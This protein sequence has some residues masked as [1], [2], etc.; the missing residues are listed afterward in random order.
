M[1]LLIRVSNPSQ[2][3]LPFGLRGV[4]AASIAA[5]FLGACAQLPVTTSE[6]SAQPKEAAADSPPAAQAEAPVRVEPLPSQPLTAQILYQLLM[7][8]IAAQRGN[9]VFASSGYLDLARKTRDPRIARRAAEIAHFSRN[10]EAALEAIRLWLEFDPGSPQ[11]R[12]MFVGLLAQANRFDEMQPHVVAILEQEPAESRGEALMRLG[13]V[14][15]RNPDRQ[16]V[17]RGIDRMTEP[18]LNLPEARLLRAQAAN[19]AGVPDRAMAEIEAAIALRP[20][21]DQAVLF[22]AQLQQKDSPAAAIETI[23]QYLARY[24]KARDVR[25][26]Y[27]RALVGE[28]RY[29]EGREQFRKLLAD[30]PDNQDVIFAVG[31][32][33]YQLNDYAVADR[34]F[35]KLLDLGHADSGTVRIYLGQIAENQKRPDDAVAWYAGVPPGEQ[36]LTAQIRLAHVLSQQGKV[37]EARRHLQQTSASTSRE[38]IQ[39]IL[40]EAQLLRE[41]GR[42]DDAFNVL[43]AG[44][45]EQPDQPDLLYE[46]ALIAEKLGRSDVLERNLR[47]LILIKPDHAHAY[48]ALGYSLAERN[49]R[50]DE[51]QSLIASALKLAPDDPF[52]LD[53]MGW[54]LYRRGDLQ[55]AL[56]HL[57]RAFGLRPDPEIAAHLGE[58]LWMLG[59]RD[60]ATKTWR[61]A[62]KANPG[63]DVLS[64]AIKR[65]L[66]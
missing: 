16:A 10:N 3:R 29:E 25:L 46:S 49:E 9:A 60:D 20:E 35:R 37:D 38:R 53:S 22:K 23:R 28:K 40:A 47:R 33:S 4:L 65:F 30:F 42:N 36:Y 8:E 32:L 55:G 27:A 50:L 66:P 12:Y 48:N 58:V 57:T 7:A 14:F 59:R 24:P 56:V 54:V 5:L 26:Q 63:N 18:Y 13:R 39:L 43:D 2:T 51:A 62:A 34:S 31:A 17:L 52:I 19:N 1:T 6:P 15:S 61:E 11:A 41:A 44:L 64:A 45:R 21:W